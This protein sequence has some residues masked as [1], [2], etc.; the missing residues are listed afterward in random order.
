MVRSVGLTVDPLGRSGQS[1]TSSPA[2]QCVV[3]LS[4]LWVGLSGRSPPEDSGR[5]TLSPLLVDSGTQTEDEP[6]PPDPN[7]NVDPPVRGGNKR[8]LA[9][10][11]HQ[12]GCMFL[13]PGWGVQKCQPVMTV[14]ESTW[15][16]ESRQSRHVVVVVE[17]G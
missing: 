10:D 3:L 16:D 2:G 7:S 6:L 4:T 11:D 17:S 12:A 9:T 8:P 15:Y 1:S 13:S 5:A 14:H